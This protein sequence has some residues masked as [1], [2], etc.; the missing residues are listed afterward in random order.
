MEN[1][2]DTYNK[3]EKNIDNAN[4]PSHYI[5]MAIGIFVTVL[6]ALLRFVANLSFIDVLSNVILVIG[7]ILC[8]KAVINILK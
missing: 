2:I 4:D 3:S 5:L 8:L 1:P 6:G 7:V